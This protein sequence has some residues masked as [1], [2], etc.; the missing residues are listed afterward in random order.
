MVPATH[1]RWM[2]WRADHVR[3]SSMSP[4]LDVTWRRENPTTWLP[5]TLIQ[6]RPHTARWDRPITTRICRSSKQ[7]IQ[8]QNYMSAATCNNSTMF[9]QYNVYRMVHPR[10]LFIARNDFERSIEHR[11]RCLSHC[12][13]WTRPISQSI[14]KFLLA[15]S[16]WSLERSSMRSTS[17]LLVQFGIKL[18]NLMEILSC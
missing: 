15:V 5:L 7:M 3:S 12:C 4:V 10:C 14:L 17:I 2:R 1:H 6:I 8:Q 11:R 18:W 13:S 16:F 9:L